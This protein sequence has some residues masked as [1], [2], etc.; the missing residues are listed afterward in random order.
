[1]GFWFYQKYWMYA[2]FLSAFSIQNKC[3][4]WYLIISAAVT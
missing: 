1:M 4:M 3:G 2:N